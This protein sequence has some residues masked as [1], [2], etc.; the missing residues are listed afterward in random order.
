MAHHR[1]TARSIPVLFVGLFVACGSPTAPDVSLPVTRVVQG[2]FSAGDAPQRLAIRSSAELRAAWEAMFRT[3]SPPPEIPTV[4]FSQDMLIVAAAG[5]KPSGGYCIS[6]E[7][8]VGTRQRVTMTVRSGGP[9]AG[10]LLPVVTHPFD[11][12]RVPRRDDV[13]FTEVSFVGNCGP[14]T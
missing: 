3:L 7:S 13:R 2:Y 10:A 6:V 12:V 8:A 14:L 9:T 1:R 5:A 11:V 4:D